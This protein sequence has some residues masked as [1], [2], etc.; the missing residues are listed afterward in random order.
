MN[1]SMEVCFT[2]E[3]SCWCW[4]YDTCKSSTPCC[5]YNHGIA[6]I[7]RSKIG[8]ANKSSLARNCHC[9]RLVLSVC[10]S[11]LLIPLL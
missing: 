8:G 5:R 6:S 3:R 7:G 11:K 10:L 2:C 1:D 9:S 4:L